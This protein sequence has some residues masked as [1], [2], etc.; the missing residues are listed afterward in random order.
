MSLLPYRMGAL[1][2]YRTLHLRIMGAFTYELW[3]AWLMNHGNSCVVWS[4]M[5]H[6]LSDGRPSRLVCQRTGRQVGRCSAAMA[7]NPASTWSIA[8]CCGFPD[9]FHF[10]S[11]RWHSWHCID[12]GIQEWNWRLDEVK[13]LILQ[14]KN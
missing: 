14:I 7:A 9:M 10:R 8:F 6:L 3:F 5:A 2:N 1:R 13:A 12:R 11:S 4:L